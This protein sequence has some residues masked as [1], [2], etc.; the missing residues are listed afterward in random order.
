MR[1]NAYFALTSNTLQFGAELELVAEVAGCGLRGHFG[2]DAL[3]Q[4]SP[5]RFVADVSGGIALR[6][7]GET[8]MG[9]SLAM[10]LEGP[11][12]Y[13][14]RGRGSIDLF[15]FE[16]SFDFEV[17]WGSPATQISAR[18]VAGDLHN[19]LQDPAAW[20]SRGSTCPGIQLTR[21]GTKRVES[22]IA[23][24]PYG[25]V[26]VNQSLV[27]LGIEIQEY[28]GIPVQPQRFDIIAGAFRY[29]DDARRP[30]EPADHLSEL[31]SEFAPGMYLASH[32]DDEALAGAPFVSLASGTQLFP[33]PA[34]GSESRPVDVTWEERVLARDIPRPIPV[35]IGV[36]LDVLAIEELTVSL[37]FDEPRWWQPPEETV[38]VA[39]Q[40]PVASATSWSM[41]ADEMV[42]PTMVEAT[43]ALVASG[44]SLMTVEQWEL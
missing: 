6:A 38:A 21:A 30:V 14:A 22:G 34:A 27:P 25:T 26:S 31:R 16:V 28:G 5:F 2:F 4:F 1:C 43:Q 29:D 33:Q 24:D 35:I 9:I 10:H 42:A 12:P 7:F 17:G 15:F 18:D 19:A 41:T 36:L 40:P 11:A 20:R 39:A 13:L 23:V 8:L 37:S 32:S 3:V 44:L